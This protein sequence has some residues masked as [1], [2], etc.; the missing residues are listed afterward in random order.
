MKHLD[1]RNV[2]SEANFVK[3]KYFRGKIVIEKLV[4]LGIFWNFL[5][6]NELKLLNSNS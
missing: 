6:I 1:P 5:C 4:F 2:D 3:K